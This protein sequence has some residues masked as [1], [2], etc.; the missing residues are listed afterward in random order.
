MY[1]I[2]DSPCMALQPGIDPF[3]LEANRA[4]SADA[5]VV[6]L[7]ALARRVDGVPAQAGILCGLRYVQPDL[8]V[9]P[10]RTGRPTTRAVSQ[11][12]HAAQCSIRAECATERHVKSARGT[13]PVREEERLKRAVLNDRAARRR[14]G[15][16]GPIERV[17]DSA[18]LLRRQSL[19]L[20]ACAE[21]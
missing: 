10:P 12:L 7:P 8:H 9:E 14:Y 4:T 1:R 18:A 6:D 13:E 20:P 5:G 17:Q 3:P 15:S 21:S 11:C 19:K 16:S 2:S